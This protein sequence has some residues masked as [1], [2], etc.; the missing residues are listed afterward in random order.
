MATGDYVAFLD[1][2]DSWHPEKNEIQYRWMERHPDVALSGTGWAIRP[3][4]AK[5]MSSKIVA[6]KLRTARLLLHN[7][8]CTS[9]VMVRRDVSRRFDERKKRSEDYLL[10]LQ[11]S[12]SGRF[13]ARIRH[14]LA[15]YHKSSFG[16]SGLS[17]DI[18]KMQAGQVDTYL[19]FWR[20][21]SISVVTCFSLIVW[22]MVKFARRV[23][24]VVAR[25][26]TGMGNE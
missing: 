16:E 24:V 15:F 7:C 10:W 5:P 8:L 17:S 6:T 9:G 18:W 21:G 20:E 14:P 1:S 19:R 3:I 11:I 2:D 12:K 22:S 26:V 4:E 13:V 23:G 25:R